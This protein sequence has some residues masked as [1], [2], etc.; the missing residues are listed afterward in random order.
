MN[1][2]EENRAKEILECFDLF[3]TKMGFYAEKK[4]KFY[5]AFGGVLSI[6][7]ILLSVLSFLLYSL[8]DLKRTSPTATSSSIP[9]EGY[10]KIKINEAKIWIPVRIT[11][12]YYNFINHEGLIYPDMRYYYVEKNNEVYELK[13]KKLNYRLCNETSMQNKPDIYSINVP[14]N[15]LYCIDTD[16]LEIGGFWDAS[17]L[18]FLK[19]DIYFCKNGENYN[20]SNPNCTT[21]EKI[22]KKIGYN[23]SIRFDIYYPTIQFQPL[24]Y[25]NPIIILYRNYFY[26]ISKYSNKIARLFLQEYVLTDDHGWFSNNI[27]NNSYWGLSSLNSDDYA[28]PETKDLINQGS[29]SRFYSLNIHLEPG[30]IL[31]KRKYKKILTIF[32]HGLPIMYI[33]FII[34]ENISKLFKSAEEN[35]IMIELLFENLK[36]KPN[37]FEE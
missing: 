10:R 18:S 35:K 26:H 1:I 23:N 36:E 28:T 32:T 37:K 19:M 14:L 25:S 31:Y 27:I 12:Y 3:G 34:F 24:N 15:K 6:I 13:Y 16:D 21:Y 11:D 5:T 9:S 33:V 2:I 7:S 22:R 17:F 29:T 8:D 4:P 30:I 20:E